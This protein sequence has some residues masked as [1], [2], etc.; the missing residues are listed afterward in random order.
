MVSTPRTI[1]A[2][3]AMSAESMSTGS[4]VDVDVG[5]RAE[6]EGEEKTHDGGPEPN[7]LRVAGNDLPAGAAGWVGQDGARSA[8]ALD[9]LGGDPP[10]L[11]WTP[12]K[13]RQCARSDP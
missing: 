13:A 7:A 6:E 11:S 12:G 9:G 3:L 8:H 5:R 4:V 2:Y 10:P 1:L